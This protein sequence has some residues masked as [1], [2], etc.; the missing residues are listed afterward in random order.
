MGVPG[1]ISS[2]VAPPG[3]AAC[4]S[5]HLVG[6]YDT[7]DFLVETVCGFVGPAL[8]DG[9]AAIV[10]ATEAHR[11]A[12][13][14]ALGASGHDVDAAVA[15]GR[16]LA[17][18]ADELIEALMVDGAPEAGR[19]NDVGGGMV[20]RATAGGHRLRI[21][22]EAV[23][24]LWGAGDIASAIALEDL[25]NG[26][27][28]RKDF[29]LMCGYPMRTFD[30]EASAAGFDRI[31][32]QH[33]TVI[34]SEGYSR[35]GAPDAQQR[36]VAKLQQEMTALRADVARLRIRQE[37]LAKL[38][39][40]DALTGLANRRAFDRHLEREWAL[41]E[42]DGLE[43]F[44]LVA[45]LDSFKECNDR[46]GHAAGDAVLQQLGVALRLAAGADGIVARIGG[47]EFGILL[48]GPEAVVHGFEDRVR[49][50]M[51]ERALHGIGPLEVTVGYAPL[52]RSHSAASAL[53]RA[54][55]AMLARKGPSRVGVR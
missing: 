3:P 30:D 50:V 8:H 11:K 36:T 47:D 14:A 49:Q 43:R 54:D 38:A 4:G 18:D 22:G 9:D 13:A 41:S 20:E 48:R 24:V 31:C 19:F 15:A 28:A 27:A 26:F 37:A 1:R 2:A 7:E 39:Y 45:D 35:F 17:F 40:L 33:T 21:Y 5:G 16:Y 51:A 34:P 42:H 10:V 29:A 6:F 23:A 53:D 52:H 25:W 12:F 55:L 32:E 44:V 46:Y